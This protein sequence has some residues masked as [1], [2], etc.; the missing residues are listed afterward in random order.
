MLSWA[1]APWGYELNIFLVLNTQELLRVDND[2]RSVAL[3]ANKLVQWVR[4]RAARS[5]TRMIVFCRCVW[6]WLL[7]PAKTLHGH[8]SRTENLVIQ[9]TCHSDDNAWHK[10]SRTAKQNTCGQ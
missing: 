5:R 10:D 2:M 4:K 8:K 1:A 3:M 7:S 9:M 6:I